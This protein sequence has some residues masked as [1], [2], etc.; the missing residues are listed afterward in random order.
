MRLRN[1]RFCCDKPHIVRVLLAEDNPRPCNTD[2]YA[3][4]ALAARGVKLYHL[5]VY[6][7]IGRLLHAS[8]QVRPGCF[9]GGATALTELADEALLPYGDMQQAPTWLPLI[10]AQADQGAGKGPGPGAAPGTGGILDALFGNM[11]FPL[12]LTLLLMYFLLMRPEQRKKKEQEQLLAN[13]KDNDHVVTSGGIYGVI[14]STSKN[15][16]VLRV[17]DKNGTKIKVLRSAISHVGSLDE[18]A[19]EDA[20]AAK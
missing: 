3:C 11:M 4:A 2:G 12:M 5:A 16:V 1:A 18:A 14:V 10:L 8:A 19:E 17:D 9:G 7:R 13:L 20:K 6:V 15:L